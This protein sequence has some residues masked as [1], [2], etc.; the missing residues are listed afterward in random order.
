[1]RRF[2]KLNHKYLRPLITG[3]KST[4]KVHSPGAHILQVYKRLNEHDALTLSR[5]PTDPEALVQWNASLKNIASVLRNHTSADLQQLCVFFAV[6]LRSV[7]IHTVSESSYVLLLRNNYC[8]VAAVENTNGPLALNRR[9]ISDDRRVQGSKY[10][11]GCSDANSTVH[12]Q[13]SAISYI[14]SNRVV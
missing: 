14:I 5:A 10:K 2:L 11:R 9:N 8:H 4:D 1:M 12:D 3:S 6:S 13:I 7:C